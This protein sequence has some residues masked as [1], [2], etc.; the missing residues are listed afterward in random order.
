V[1][2]LQEEVESISPQVTALLEKRF[3]ARASK[4]WSQSDALRA[5][6]ESLGW[7]VKDTKEG[8][9]LIKKSG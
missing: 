7:L 2:Q 3:E 5:Q 6:I 4:N 1:L 9:K 8:Q